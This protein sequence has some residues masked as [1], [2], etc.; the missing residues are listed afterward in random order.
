MHTLSFVVS[1]GVCSVLA[2]QGVIQPVVPNNVPELGIATISH[3]ANGQPIGAIGQY[4]LRPIGAG[5]YRTV[6]TVQLQGGLDSQLVAGT[7]DLTTPSPTWQPNH[8]LDALNQANSSP[9]ESQGSMSADGLA[10]VWDNLEGATYPA[11]PMPRHSFVCRRATSS[12]PFA[13]SA[14]RAIAGV[15]G[16]G[17]NPH[18]GAEFANGH[19]LLFF[20]DATGGISKGDLDP[21]SGIVTGISVAAH[22][23]NHVNLNYAYAPFVQRDSTG[24]P[25][26]LSFTEYYG[27]PPNDWSSGFWTAGIDDDGSPTMLANGAP[28]GV[29]TYCYSN[30]AVVGG[31]WLWATEGASFGDP[32][33]FEGNAIANT[34]L[35]SGSGRIVAFA[36]VR[37]GGGAPLYSLVGIGVPAAPFPVPPVIGSLLLLPTIGISDLRLHDADTGL[38]EW[39]FTGVP[40]GLGGPFVAQ[41]VTLD[42]GTGRLIAG[43]AAALLVP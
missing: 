33:L 23:S 21:I 42:L 41:V 28:G 34:D 1:S 26:A 32:S 30:P 14:V 4:E 5:H 3:N 43:N 37:P 39:T 8:D 13:A 22:R 10:I 36:P 12:V 35:R 19:L 18:I 7:V 24:A 38:A 25:R 20:V 11:V 27:T 16:S 15:P 6:L 31:S 40:T 9:D 2:A 17:V 29:P